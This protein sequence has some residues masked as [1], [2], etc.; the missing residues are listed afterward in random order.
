MTVQLGCALTTATSQKLNKQTARPREHARANVALHDRIRE[1]GLPMPLQQKYLTARTIV[2]IEA[3]KQS[4]PD[5]KFALA[6]RG[7][8]HKLPK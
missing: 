4:H 6:G 1:C 3:K 5:V 2:E 8:A 7:H